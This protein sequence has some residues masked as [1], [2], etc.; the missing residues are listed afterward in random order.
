LRLLADKD[1]MHWNQVQIIPGDWHSGM[2]Y[3]VCSETK[4]EALTPFIV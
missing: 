4:I 3:S 1:P 2:C